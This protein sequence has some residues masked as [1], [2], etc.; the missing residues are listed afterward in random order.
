[1]GDIFVASNLLQ[2]VIKTGNAAEV[3]SARAAL[4][5]IGET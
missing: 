3:A 1:M 2:E 4:Q 5:K